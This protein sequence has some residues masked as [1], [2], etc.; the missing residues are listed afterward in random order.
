[1]GLVSRVVPVDGAVGAALEI[2][3]TIAAN[4]ML[5]VSPTKTLLQVTPRATTLREASLLEDP[6]QTVAVC[7]DDVDRASRAFRTVEK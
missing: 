7:A 1:V 3:R 6:T 4:P 2:A 5:G